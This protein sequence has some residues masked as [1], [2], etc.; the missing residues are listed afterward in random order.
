MTLEALDRHDLV[1]VRPGGP[2]PFPHPLPP[3]ARSAWDAAG[4]PLILRRGSAEGGLPLGLPLPI[5]MGKR[6]IGLVLAPDRVCPRPTPAPSAV[7][8][9]APECW[10][11]TLHAAAALGRTFGV[12]VT[13][14]GALL[15]QALLGLDYLHAGSDLD[16]LWRCPGPVPAGLLAALSDLA[17]RAPM[18]IDGEIVVG[19]QGVQWRE[20][21]LAWPGDR[22]LCRS[23]AGVGW[24]P[25]GEFLAPCPA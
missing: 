13:P 17:A 15:W 19:G 11:S 4:R 2:D 9:R 10:R 5:S 8:C 22:L 6:R 23:R 16:L 12:T 3:A 18:R 21:A 24:R 20:L 7:A 14:Y 1:T 25:A